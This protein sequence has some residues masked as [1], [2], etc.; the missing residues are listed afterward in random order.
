MTAETIASAVFSLK[1]GNPVEIHERMQDIM[2]R[3]REKQP[4]EYPSAGSAFKRPQN[5]YASSLIDKCGL[6]GLR[7]GGAMVSTKH[8]GFIFNTGCATCSDVLT[9]C[10]KIKC[11][12]EDQTG[13]LLETEI[14]KL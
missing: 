13:I 5:G 10:E 11:V 7:I 1:P 12:V 6:K 14:K 3:R 9:L 8:A 4:L 2:N